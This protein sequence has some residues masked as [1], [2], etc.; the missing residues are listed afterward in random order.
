MWRT[1]TWSF[2]VLHSSQFL[3][4]S[5][6]QFLTPL[7][8]RSSHR[9][10]RRRPSY[11]LSREEMDPNGNKATE[12]G[13]S[14]NVPPRLSETSY[15]DEDDLVRGC[16]VHSSRDLAEV[17]FPRNHLR[18]SLDPLCV[19]TSRSSEILEL[20]FHKRLFFLCLDRPSLDAITPLVACLICNTM[21]M[22]T[23]CF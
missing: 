22:S 1:A 16:F 4:S 14:E 10:T 8:K 17:T 21:R 3:T 9:S 7:Q 2:A 5:F 12:G 23:A 19:S 6:V 18:G 11:A 20:C 13:P 15:D